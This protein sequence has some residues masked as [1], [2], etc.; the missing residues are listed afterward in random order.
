MKYL[1]L[2][3]AETVRGTE[4][5]FPRS[6]RQK[7]MQL[8]RVSMSGVS[9]ADKLCSSQ[10]HRTP[11]RVCSLAGVWYLH[12]TFFKLYPHI[13]DNALNQDLHRREIFDTRMKPVVG[14]LLY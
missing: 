1:Y 7:V 9:N 6:H 10:G 14:L 8:R 3:D 12:L 5:M 4:S 2:V 11:V 13:F